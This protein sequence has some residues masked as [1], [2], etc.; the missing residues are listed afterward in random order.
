MRIG[1]Y[2]LGDVLEE[3]SLP[4]LTEAEYALLPR[5]FEDERIFRAGSADF[6]GR[7]CEVVLGAIKGRIYK[8][9]AQFECDS[10]AAAAVVYADVEKHCAR[11]FGLSATNEAATVVWNTDFGNVVLDRRSA[12]D[13]HAV[14]LFLTSRELVGQASRSPGGRRPSRYIALG[15]QA[16]HHTNDENL[17]WAWL[18]A[19]EWGH[20]PLFWS[21]PVV[22]L[23]LLIYPLWQICAMLVVC[24]LAWAPVRYRFVSIRAATAAV[25]A[26]STRWVTG[27]GSAFLLMKHG[28]WVIAFIALFW[29]FIAPVLGMMMPPQI[30]RIQ[31]QFM[32]RLGYEPTDTNPLGA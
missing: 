10:P 25:I 28:R 26:S 31:T 4:E 24:E 17:R 29:P 11:E 18:R 21:L 23:L 1:G 13:Q 22:P 2:A 32:R 19:V 12:L 6:R 30:G 8:I 15:W 27:P 7:P 5:E 16:S 14:S 20:W 9:A 3:S